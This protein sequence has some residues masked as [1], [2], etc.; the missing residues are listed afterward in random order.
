M[1]T[2]YNAFQR[3][4]IS[5]TLVEKFTA[6]NPETLQMSRTIMAVVKV[7][8]GEQGEQTCDDCSD[9]MVTSTLLKLLKPLDIPTENA[10]TS[11]LLKNRFS[12]PF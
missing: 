8:I 11:Q 10:S 9:A 1:L 7:A 2:P 12:T 5:T 6:I 4:Q 3:Y